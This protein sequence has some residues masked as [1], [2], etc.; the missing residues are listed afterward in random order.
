[1]VSLFFMATFIASQQ[2]AVSPATW[3]LISELVPA[4]V[5]GLGMGIAGLS[6]WVTNWAVAQYFLPLVEWLTGPVAF[7]I[8]G[9]LGII[10][11]GYTRALVPETMGKSLDEVGAEM[12]NRYA[13]K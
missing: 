7:A 5:R 9:V 4:Q 13:H 10:A 1:M 6:L 3:L 2:A 11:M 8:F 12:H